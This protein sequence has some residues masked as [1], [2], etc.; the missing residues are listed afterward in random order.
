M[1]GLIEQ[2]PAEV[3]GQNVFSMLSGRDFV[4]LDSAIL[5][6]EA[7]LALH[8]LFG[9]Q[10]VSQWKHQPGHSAV[11]WFTKK[12][13]RVR[14]RELVIS[15]N[16]HEVFSLLAE[17]KIICDALHLSPFEQH[18]VNEIDGILATLQGNPDTQR[19]RIKLHPHRVIKFHNPGPTERIA[20]EHKGS[21][22]TG[23][24]HAS[25]SKSQHRANN[26]TGRKC[27]RVAH[28]RLSWL[29]AAISISG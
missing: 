26:S 13:L 27:G 8:A 9:S 5:N 28:R 23:Y 3:V 21:N 12:G 22:S 19:V 20:L 10:T 2:L 7:R 18:V 29:I 6:K 11:R 24:P 17:S 15:S 16:F 14:L 25:A 1:W 4:R